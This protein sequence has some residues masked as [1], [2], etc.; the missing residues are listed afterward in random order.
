MS[1][2][3]KTRLI[4][5]D[6]QVPQG[7]QSLNTPVYRAS[8]VVFKD[9]ACATDN[10]DQYEAG[11][12]YGLH[13]TPTTLEL[14]ARI[15]ELEKGFRTL[16]TPGGQAAISL[17]HLAL[18]HSGDHVLL[19]ESIYG[20]N[21]K[22]CNDVLRRFAVEVGYYPPTAGPDF[23]SWLRPNTDRKSVV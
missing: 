22:F 21:R 19:P 18:L 20:P 6:A 7:F 3:W 13:G 23:K 12:T 8:T 5:S 10:W 16:I 4:H 2:D 14:A 11:Y 9:V 15:C 1:K 17:I